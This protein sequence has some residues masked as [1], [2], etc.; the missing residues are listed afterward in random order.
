M[1]KITQI[2]KTRKDLRKQV[3]KE[4]EQIALHVIH[5]IYSRPLRERLMIVINI[6]FKRDTGGKND[7]T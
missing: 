7:A 6:L 5:E 1:G 4:R 2:K 3:G